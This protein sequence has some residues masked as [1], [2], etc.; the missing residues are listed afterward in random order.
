MSILLPPVLLRRK[1]WQSTA[2]VMSQNFR[3]LL[4]QP[5]VRWEPLAT[6]TTPSS[7]VLIIVLLG[8]WLQ[9]QRFLNA[10]FY[11]I[12]CLF[13]QMWSFSETYYSRNAYMLLYWVFEL[14]YANLNFFCYNDSLYTS[15]FLQGQMENISPFIL[16]EQS[17]SSCSWVQS[18]VLRWWQ[19]Y[20]YNMCC[21]K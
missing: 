20:M 16:M 8:L 15:N 18:H 14:H 21:Q 7:Q 6:G 3:R 19:D 11:W 12:Q 1:H 4:W 2:S 5:P 10:F 17:F 9:F 13:C